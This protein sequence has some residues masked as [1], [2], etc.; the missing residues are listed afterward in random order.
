VSLLNPRGAAPSRGR[1]AR[2]RGGVARADLA[3]Q[4][5]TRARGRWPAQHFSRLV[6]LPA[7]GV[8]EEAGRPEDKPA[9][10]RTMRNHRSNEPVT[11]SS[12]IPPAFAMARDAHVIASYLGTLINNQ[13]TSGLRLFG[14]HE[15]RLKLPGTPGF[16]FQWDI[17]DYPG[18]VRL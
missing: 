8:K 6:F 9:R 1:S 5:G 10:G 16:M 4:R 18:A 12:Y 14:Y 2:L 15:M 13:F 11:N 17:Q 3:L 7:R